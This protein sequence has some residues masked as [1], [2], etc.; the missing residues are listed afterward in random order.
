LISLSIEGSADM[1]FWSSAEGA[2][3]ALSLP[4]RPAEP[5]SGQQVH[6]KVKYGLTRIG[7]IIDNHSVALQSF[8]AGNLAGHQEQVTQEITLLLRGRR[9]RGDMLFGDDENMG[10]GLGVDISKGKRP[11]V[12]LDDARIRFPLDN[13][14]K[15]A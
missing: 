4:R 6:V 14:A 2:G 13:L 12:F 11:L 1:I 5:P 7:P 3:L 10:G 8:C 9:Q 15:N